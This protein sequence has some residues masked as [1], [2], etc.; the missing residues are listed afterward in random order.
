MIEKYIQSKSSIWAPTTIKSE[1][2]RLKAI[3]SALD[4]NPE[5]LWKALQLHGRYT[6]LTTWIRVIDYWNQTHHTTNSTNPYHAYKQSNP[7]KFRRVYERRI[8][9]ITFE[10]AREQI[11][12]IDDLEVR[13]QGLSLLYSGQRYS[14]SIQVSTNGNVVGKGNKQR[15]D[16]RPETS[17]GRYGKSYQTFRRRLSKLGLKPHDL[18]KICLSKL[19]EL[20]ANEFE[21]M[22][23]AGWSS[24]K[25]AS[26]YIRTNRTKLNQLMGRLPK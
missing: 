8:P 19:V 23:I 5:T 16:F 1:K 14:E 25:V 26:S 4:G 7:T 17:E 22:E 18:R 6:R 10:Q 15:P 11:G 12:T 24:I 21:L 3:E 13:R 9:I 2:H 20:G